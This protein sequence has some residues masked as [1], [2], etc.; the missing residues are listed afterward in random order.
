MKNA[1][2]NRVNSSFSTR[3]NQGS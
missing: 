2:H 3:W 1:G